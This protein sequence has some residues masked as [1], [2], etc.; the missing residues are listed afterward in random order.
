MRSA[1]KQLRHPIGQYVTGQPV[2][3]PNFEVSAGP[4][5]GPEPIDD[6]LLIGGISERCLTF[7]DAV[8]Q[9]VFPAAAAE[10]KDA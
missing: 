4:N 10:I 3:V 1:G 8:D 5:A 9:L 7:P 2:V 6:G